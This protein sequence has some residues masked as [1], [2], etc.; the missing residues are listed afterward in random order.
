MCGIVGYIGRNFAE[1][2]VVDGLKRLEYRGYDSAGLAAPQDGALKLRRKVG[3][4]ANLEREILREPAEAHVG[5]GHTRWA[6]HG[7]PTVANTH[8]HTDSAQTLAVVHNGIIEN[9]LE[10]R[11]KL[12]AD[13]CVFSSATDTEVVPQ[14]VAFHMT[15]GLGLEAAFRATLRRLEGS[16][17]L[18]LVCAREPDV[19]L[20]ARRSSPLVVGFGPDEFLVAS[21]VLAIQA[22][23]TEVIYL[24]DGDVCVLKPTGVRITDVD[25]TVMSRTRHRVDRESLTVQKEGHRHFMAKEIHEQPRVLAQTISGRLAEGGRDVVLSDL[26]LTAAAMRELEHV[27]IVACGT[28][29]HAGLVGRYLIEGLAGIPVR[30]DYASEFRGSAALLPRRSLLI[31]ISQ[32]G[33]TA[34]TLNA[35]RT[36]K[37]RSV[38]TLTICN[39]PRSSMVRESD[40]VIQTLVGP[41]IG[42]ASTKA[43]SGQLLSLAMLAVRLG[44][45]RS[46]LSP[47]DAGQLLEHM[48]RLPAL[49][50]HALRLETDVIEEARRLQEA[51]SVL[52]LGRG[53]N[54]PVALEGALKL[55]EISYIHAE[56]Y[57]AGELKHGPIALIDP[58]FPVVAVA[59]AGGDQTRL[60]SNLAEVRAREAHVLLIA[61]DPDTPAEAADRVLTVPQTSPWLEPIMLVLPLQMLA[62][63]TAVLKGCDV[64]QPRNLAKSVTVE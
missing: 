6:T 32:S 53:I 48:L 36:V 21:D 20:A 1:I 39:A 64:D 40:G 15:Q 57:P 31:T 17:A 35:L 46:A 27:Q 24:E 62:Y 52:Y 29:W 41:E 9:Y 43:F 18:A 59:G 5:I 45:T 4:I 30:V 51:R 14:L 33:E 60:L 2:V 50:E 19:I 12:E 63:H 23:A 8:P 58:R 26:G 22:Y 16:Y 25:G 37:G 56:G 7:A 54:Y 11:Q 28:S 47:T 38:P 49:L 3:K 42:V 13:G 44:V 61:V 34:D 10:I 55:K